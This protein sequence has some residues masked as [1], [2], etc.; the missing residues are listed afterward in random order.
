M[1]SAYLNNPDNIPVFLRKFSIV[2]FLISSIA[3]CYALVW[4]REILEITLSSEFHASYIIFG[5]ACLM[6]I[7][8]GLGQL[9]GTALIATYNGGVEAKLSLIFVPLGMGFTF[10]AIHPLFFAGD[11]LSLILKQFILQIITVTIL[12]YYLEKRLGYRLP[13][14]KQIAFIIASICTIYVSKILL[15]FLIV[16]VLI[17]MGISLMFYL[18]IVLF[19]VRV[20]LLRTLK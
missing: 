4:S 7:H 18:G 19:I 10:I 6:P 17:S 14:V 8:Q 9:Y 5:L 2:L 16:D 13:V 12:S 15:E 1:S 20:Y 3:G 11:A